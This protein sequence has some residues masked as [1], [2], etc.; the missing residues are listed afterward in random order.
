VQTTQRWIRWPADTHIRM[1]AE[2]NG[3]MAFGGDGNPRAMAR[4]GVA[5]RRFDAGGGSQPRNGRRLLVGPRD[6]VVAFRIT[7]GRSRRARRSSV[8]SRPGRRR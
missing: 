3:P 5:R 7:K 6:P 1:P 8:T 2:G 4:G